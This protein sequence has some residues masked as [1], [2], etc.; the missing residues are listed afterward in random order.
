M[1]HAAGGVLWRP[2][3]RDEREMAIVHRPRHDDWTLP[4]GKVRRDEHRLAAAV[5]EVGEE[6]GHVPVLGPF[7]G[8]YRYALPPAGARRDG[9]GR[10]PARRHKAVAYW[11][12][13]AVAGEFTASDEVDD[14]VWLPTTLARRCLTYTMDRRLLDAFALTPEWTSTIAVV[15]N[16]HAD[17]S[18]GP[19]ER[20]LD[21]RGRVEAEGLVPVLAALGVGT[22]VSGPYVRCRDTLAP[23]A[24]AAGL[25]VE[26][27]GGLGHSHAVG[28]DLDGIAARLLQLAARP[29]TGEGEV[30][31]GGTSVAVCA[32][33]DAVAPLVETLARKAGHPRPTPAVVRKGGWWLL[34][35][36]GSRMVAVERH[37]PWTRGEG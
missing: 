12:M 21:V 14:L 23:Y 17:G 22:L 15:R 34:H 25:A 5:R 31:S 3:R 4:K 26:V 8:R 1:V 37:L 9:A 18:G 6:T 7:V 11:S 19:A 13:R 2:G 30:L 20:P 24:E 27:E 16:A 29:R 28:T 35:L 10:G 32:R 33:G 36:D